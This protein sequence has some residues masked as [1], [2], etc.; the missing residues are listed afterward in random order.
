MVGD[1]LPLPVAGQNRPL[2]FLLPTQIQIEDFLL[3]FVVLAPHGEVAKAF[4]VVRLTTQPS[5]V[6][7]CCCWG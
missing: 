1:V 7:R 6:C 2:S 4:P 5:C 3:M